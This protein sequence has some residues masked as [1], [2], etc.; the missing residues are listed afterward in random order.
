MIRTAVRYHRPATVNDA[1][2]LLEQH[3]GHAAVLAGGTQLLPRMFRGDSAV[4]HL[5]DARDLGL[6]SATVSPATATPTIIEIG[7]LV[8]YESILADPALRRACPLLAEVAAG[9]T[10]G[11]ALTGQAT[12]IGSLC[13]NTP[14]SEIP[15]VFTALD[16]QVLLHGPHRA[17]TVPV[18]TFLRDAH[19]IDLGPGELVRAVRFAAVPRTGY[20]KIK[21]T[22]G[23][24]PIAT[25]T[26]R[27]DTHGHPLVTLGGVDAL[28]RQIL[29]HD[30]APDALDRQIRDAL[31]RP[32]SDVL[33]SSDYRTAVAPVAAKRA[34]QALHDL[35]ESP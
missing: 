6:A 4:E 22:T 9:I 17:R 26:A 12:L 35:E 34:I 3:H 10:G 19:E 7:A 25:A 5:V 29:V 15:A 13:Q 16:A 14:G 27:Y 28:P 8:T 2:A 18:A 31:P 24:W 30:P 11:R 20:C 33:A 23:S 1:S 32:W 21:H